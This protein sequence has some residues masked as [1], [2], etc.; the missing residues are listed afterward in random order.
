MR[1]RLLALVAALALL[2]GGLLAQG[3]NH[4]GGTVTITNSAAVN[5]ATVLGYTGTKN[6]KQLSIRIVP[7]SANTIY[8]GSSGVTTVPA[9]AWVAINSATPSYTWAPGGGSSINPAS[10]Y[11]I[12]TTGD[13]VA[14]VDGLE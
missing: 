13:T 9:N 8:C 11:C 6:A 2:G 14:Y 1:L 10:V 12:A 5:L 7:G 3:A 4:F